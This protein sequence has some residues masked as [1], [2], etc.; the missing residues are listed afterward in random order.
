M[1]NKIKKGIAIAAVAVS[2]CA[3]SVGAIPKAGNA[4]VTAEAKENDIMDEFLISSWLSYYGTNVKSYAEQTKELAEAGLNFQWH[5]AFA[6][7][8]PP[9]GESDVPDYEGIE[10]LYSQYGIKYLYDTTKNKFDADL[11]ENLDNCI[12][13]YIKDEPSAAQFQATKE[14][15]LDYLEKDPSRRPFVNLYPSYAGTTALGG[16]YADYVNNWIDT[17]GA[18]NMEYLYYDHYPFTATETVRST[19]F[20]DMETIRKAAYVN[21]KIKTG[22]FSQTGWWSGMRKPN[23]DELRWNL[24]TLVAYGFKSISHFCWVSPKRVSLEDGGEDMRDHIIDEDGNKTE[25]FDAMVNHNWELRQ[26]GPLLMGIDCAHAYHSGAEIPQ[27][28]EA[29]PKSFPIQPED[30]NSNYIISLF[31]SKDGNDKYVM[32]MN[33]STDNR[34]SGAFTVD[35]SSGIKSFTKYSTTIDPENLPDYK[36][37]KN[38]LG[39]LKTEEVSVSGGRITE[40]FL[41]GEVKIYK[42]NGDDVIINEG[43][44]TPEI[45]LQSGT[46]IGGIKVA[47]RSAQANAKIYYTTD[48]SFPRVDKSGN[49]FGTT[50]IYTGP[51]DLGEDGEWKYYGVRAASVIGGEYSQ[52]A[53]ADYFISDGERNVSLGK[54]V[55]FYDKAF[56]NTISV[57]SE[58]KENAS[59][60]V[61]TDGAHDP[62]TEVFTKKDQNGNNTINGWA[63][64]DLGNVTSVNKIVTS[65]WCNWEFD[66]VIIQTSTDMS[67]WQTVFNNDADGSMAAVTN[68]VGKDGKYVDEMYSGQI[69]T[70]EPRAVRYIRAYNV[71]MG[72]GI[73]NGK[74]IWQEI[75]AFSGFE[76]G[77]NAEELLT[78]YPDL[79]S[80]NVLGG[81]EWSLS[82]GVMSVSGTG[83]W[84]RAM[85]FN[86]KKY[87]NFIVE[88]TFSMTDVTAGLVGFQLYKTTPSGIL[89]GDNGYVVFIENGGR[90]GAYDGVNGGYMEFGDLNVKALNFTPDEFTFR[91]TSIND[92]LTI[93]VNGVPAYSTR[94][95][96]ADMDAGY[97]AVHAGS[98]GITVQNV[99]IMGL[100]GD[101]NIS[102]TN[103]EDCLYEQSEKVERAVK[104]LDEK[105]VAIAALPKEVTFTTAAKKQISVPVLSWDCNDYVRTSAGW[106]TFTAT[107]DESALNGIVN[108]FSL[109]ATA[110]VWVSEGFDG[111]TLQ[112]YIDIVEGLDPYDFT[113]ESWHEVEQKYRTAVEIINDPFTVQNS[114]NVASWQLY[115]AINALVNVNQDK[116]ALTELL[117]TCDYEE[118]KYT[119]VS[120]AN[121]ERYLQAA[122]EVEKSNIASQTEIDQA[123]KNLRSAISKLVAIYDKTDLAAAV[124]RAKGIDGTI[125]TEESYAKLT[126][127]IAQAEKV[128]AMENV[129]VTVGELA[130]NDLKKAE[131]GLKRIG[132]ESSTASDGKESSSTGKKKGCGGMASGCAALASLGAAAIVALKKRKKR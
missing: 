131:G 110:K 84:N 16:T 80:W 109:N 128:L 33:N 72:A 36:D 20:S 98:I 100:D 91:V 30:K 42:I 104:L 5:A 54:P 120:F 130:E 105:S 41:P 117:A 34:R 9:K 31:Y 119:E 51:F 4:E 111:T 71:G 6:A 81:S 3:F 59:G 21:G 29:L 24:N 25:I 92:L 118:D 78:N 69:F 94:N 125:Y 61:V 11:M 15:Y 52:L 113:S 46:Y 66:D 89:N 132:E 37:V 64:V 57:D 97:I 56:K 115:E 44:S 127:A 124:E 106:N 93:T 17:I 60:A 112:K 28:A 58:A 50:S 70:F 32:I 26:L 122:R 107:L 73:L 76:V 68:E 86:Q 38:T 90:V 47:I 79:S 96:R 65:F 63:V 40:E 116:S 99:W 114:V 7:A 13:Y 67:T 19:Y 1:K 12:G 14:A 87:K 129:T 23:E 123:V 27:G 45:A 108:L 39:S 53:E 95:A 49:P 22:G 75:S 48:G 74:S 83:D 103:F 77:E 8:C 82:G 43:V 55:E 10:Q 102:A 88:G 121:Y 35:A 18:E 85:V 101:N 62:F 126:A 2:A